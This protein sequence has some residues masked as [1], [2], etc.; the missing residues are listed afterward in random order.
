MITVV[1]YDAGNLRSVETALEYLGA[2]YRVSP[3]PA[4]IAA[5]DKILFPGVGEAAHAMAVLRKRGIP[6][7]LTEAVKKGTSVLGICIGSQ[8]IL[9][10]S[11]EGPTECLGLE[12]GRARYFSSEFHT[13]GITGLKVPHMGWN[14]VRVNESHPS[15]GLFRGIPENSSFYFVHSYYPEPLDASVHL[16]ETEYGFP[17][18][19]AYGRENLIACQFHPEKSGPAGLRLLDNFIRY[20]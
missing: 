7:A 12:A 11:D 17:F 2:S 10:A 19:S 5:A 4:D 3:D 18:V 15:A 6:Q 20:F 9:D 16:A 14:Q 13:H 1:D 8:I